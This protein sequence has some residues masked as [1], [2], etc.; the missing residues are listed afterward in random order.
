MASFISRRSRRSSASFCR[1]MVYF[2]MGNAAEDRTIR[3]AHAIIN[4]SSVIPD[5][6]RDGF[7]P[8]PL[9]TRLWF[10]VSRNIIR[11]IRNYGWTCTVASLVISGIRFCCESFAFTCTID[12]F[13]EPGARPLITIPSSVPLPLTPAVFGPR[14]AE[15]I[16]WPLSLKGWCMNLSLP[17]HLDQRVGARIHRPQ[18]RFCP[19]GHSHDSRRQHDQHFILLVVCFI[20]RKQVAKQR[21]LREARPAFQCL[22]V[23]PL[24]QAAEYADFA[25]LQANVILDDALADDR[26]RNTTNRLIARMRRDFHFQF[27]SD[28]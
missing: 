2:A 13:D 27:Q 10:K 6:E 11:T 16:D 12:R 1:M 19:F 18:I 23:G 14:V 24:D 22:A 26:L 21:K 20:V 3:I 4:S 7:R 15:I 25:F 5:S 8:I 17:L 28:F 9:T